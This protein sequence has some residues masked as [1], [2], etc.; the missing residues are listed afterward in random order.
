M[1]KETSP[2]FQVYPADYLADINTMLMTIEEEG[3]YWRLMLTCWRE[4]S[5]PNDPDALA[6]LCKGVKPTL[7]VM[8]C[9]QVDSHGMLRHPRLDKERK[10][11]QEWI[12][13]SRD[14][15][16]KSAAKR[17]GYK[18]NKQVTNPTEMVTPNGNQSGNQTVTLQSS[19]SIA[20]SSSDTPHKPPK[21]HCELGACSNGTRKEC[22]EAFARFWS[23][24]P[25]HEPGK[26]RTM[27]AWCSAWRCAGGLPIDSIL[28]WIS[29]AKTSEQWQDKGLI[30]HATTWLNQ[31]RWEG[32][33]PP[34]PAAIRQS[35]EAMR[36][37]GKDDDDSR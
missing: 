16:Y 4:G 13:K 1:S 29:Q 24:Y 19:F 15:G 20:S 5:L 7:L 17:W 10:K 32:D 28:G 30:P 3:C 21:G 35:S 6:Q 36:L 18:R 9:F 22:I 33:V 8:S 27:K 11:Q 34:P 26:T 14:A 2:A 31:R 25:R 12:T 37:F 23:E